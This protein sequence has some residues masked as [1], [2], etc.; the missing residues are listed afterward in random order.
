M[1]VSP[2]AR[3]KFNERREISA[4][5]RE[6][7]REYISST[8]LAFWD[9]LSRSFG[10]LVSQLCEE[11]PWWLKEQTAEQRLLAW[12]HTAEADLALSIV[13]RW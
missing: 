5:V 1:V 4:R 2:V 11:V 10:D 3:S 8:I 7:A 13:V 6:S 9:I 12:V